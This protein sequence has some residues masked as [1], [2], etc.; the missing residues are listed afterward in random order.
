M[1]ELDPFSPEA[2][3]ARGYDAAIV[4]IF[5][6][7][8]LPLLE[9]LWE[10]EFAFYQEMLKNTVSNDELLK[11]YQLAISDP[12]PEVFG[13]FGEE[14]LLLLLQHRGYSQQ[15]LAALDIVSAS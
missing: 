14:A 12:N 13:E 5:K 3:K 6:Q 9:F 1:S 2:V 7:H 10:S 11:Q 4:E 8:S 15:A